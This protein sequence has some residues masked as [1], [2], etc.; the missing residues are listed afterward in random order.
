VRLL[1][2]LWGGNMSDYSNKWCF[3]LIEYGYILT[4]VVEADVEASLVD[5]VA[6][7]GIRYIY[8]YIYK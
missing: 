7:D 8:T 6:I 1:W 5:N 3:L 4:V 2:I